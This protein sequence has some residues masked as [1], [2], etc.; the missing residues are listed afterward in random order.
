[1]DMC[2]ALAQNAAKNGHL[3]ILQ[4]ARANGCQWRSD[5]CECAA[6]NGHLE[7]L[8]WARNNGCPWNENTQKIAKE[9]W[10]NIFA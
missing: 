5:T 10:P 8:Q 3:K 7:I 1:M 6:Q 9:K 2:V 4:W